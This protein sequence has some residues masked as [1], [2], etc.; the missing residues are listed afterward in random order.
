M[1]R[2]AQALAVP[3][4]APWLIA[5]RWEHALF[6][7]WPTDPCRLRRLLPA[8]VEP[9]VREGSAWI[10]IVAFLM[11]GTRSRTGPSWRGLAPIPELNVRTYVRVGRL[12]GVWFLSLDTTSPLFVAAGRALFGL[13]YRLARMAVAPEPDAVHFLS[14]GAGGT[15]AAT[16]A[17]T[18]PPAEAVPGSLEHFLVERYRLF[19]TVGGRVITARVTHEPWPL[20]PAAAKIALNRMAPPGVELNGEPLLHFSRSVSARISAPERVRPE[21]TAVLAG[22]PALGPAPRG[23][24]GT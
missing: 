18:E 17:P 16:Y 22:V 9:D 11:A 5:Q 24:I 4:R 10:A 3:R 6:A 2:R 19:S 1:I 12:D 8:S 15:F 20:Q 13:R 23:I 14:D 7:H 21:A